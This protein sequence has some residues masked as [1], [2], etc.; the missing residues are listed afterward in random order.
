ML[1][2][3]A[4]GLESPAYYHCSLIRDSTGQRM[5]KRH[6]SLSIRRLR[7]S[8]KSPQQVLMLAEELAK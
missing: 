5:A 1:I 2:F 3:R 8:R 7:E 4:L 6:D